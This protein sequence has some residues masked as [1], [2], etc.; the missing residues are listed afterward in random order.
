MT[1]VFSRGLFHI[2]TSTNLNFDKMNFVSLYL[3]TSLNQASHILTSLASRPTTN[4]VV[5]NECIQPCMHTEPAPAERAAVKTVL[6]CQ[7]FAL[8]MET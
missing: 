2:G 1:N 3:G 6:S 7:S 8:S 5:E 4:H